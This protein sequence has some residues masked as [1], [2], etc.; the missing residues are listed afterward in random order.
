MRASRWLFLSSLFL[1]PSARANPQQTPLAVTM[2]VVATAQSPSLTK[3]GQY[4]LLRG[5]AHQ[6]AAEVPARTIVWTLLATGKRIEKSDT[7]DVGS[8]QRVIVEKDAR[9]ILVEMVY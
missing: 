9:F 5:P 7:A 4:A 6:L 2:Q 1:V 8:W 3:V